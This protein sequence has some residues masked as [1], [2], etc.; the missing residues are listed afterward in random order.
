MFICRDIN[1]KIDDELELQFNCVVLHMKSS[2][3]CS[4]RNLVFRV[5]SLPRLAGD[6]VKHPQIRF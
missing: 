4:D 1:M 3:D 6:V 5:G 2:I